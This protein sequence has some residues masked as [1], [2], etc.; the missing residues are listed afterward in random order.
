MRENASTSDYYDYLDRN[1]TFRDLAI[2]GSGTAV[3]VRPDADPL[4]LNAAIVS[5]NLA[6]VL[7]IDMQ[8]GRNFRLEEDVP[9]GPSVTVLT[10]RL[11]RDA[12]GADPRVVGSSLTIDDRPFEV[13][14]VLPAGLDYPARQTD[15]WVPI[16]QSRATAVRPQHWV[17][18][19]GRLQA[20]ATVASAQADMAR[21]MAD[22]EVE[23]A[24]DNQN[25]GAFVEK[26]ADVGRAD[27]RSTLWVLFASVLAVLAIACV[28]VANLLLARG[29]SRSRELAVLK[30]VGAGN[31]HITRKFIVEG[32][33][34]TALAAASG[35]GLAAGGVRLLTVL[36]PPS[37]L[38]LGEPAMNLQVLTFALGTGALICIGFGL[39]PALQARGLDVHEHLKDGGTTER[40]TAG[41]VLR[42]MLVAG[43]LSLAVVLLLGATLLIGT[44]RNLQSIDPGF[45]A[46]NSL[47]V[48][49]ALPTRYEGSLDTYPNWPVMQQFLS[50]L[51]A[52]AE[53]IPGIESATVVT[54]HPLDAGFTNSFRIEG[55]AYDPSQGEMTT[56]L[57]TPGYFE[58]TGV[59]LLAGRRLD[60]SDRAGAPDA[61][62]LNQSAADRYFPEGDAVGK[63]IAFWGPTF[64]E[65]VGIIGNERL[66]GLTAEIPPAMYVSMYQ[67]PPLRGGKDDVDGAHSGGTAVGGRRRA[68]RHAQGRPRHSG[69]QRVDHGSD[70]R[71]RAG[72]RAVRVHGAEPIRWCGALFGDAWRAR[73]A[74]LSG[75]A[76]QSRSGRAHGSGRDAPGRG[77][78]GGEAGRLDD[79][80]RNR[81]RARSGLRR[82][83]PDSGS[84][85]RGQRDR[86][87][88]VRGRRDHTRDRGAGRSGCAGAPC[89]IDQP[90]VV[91]T[92]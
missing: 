61:I 68:R 49:F 24:N 82:V 53:A 89:R 69:L 38:L 52:E 33:L 85:L 59:E 50:D 70:G 30:A 87:D 47:R 76:A 23:Y 46:E 66:H 91:A 64:R 58:T 86:A 90:G 29:A 42:R 71:R 74:G 92:R 84:A 34:I 39:L 73:R 17:R 80:D 41:F 60:D 36:A 22:L 72:S 12:F 79:R 43:Q 45:R 19:V 75:G 83:R 28:N 10:D 31:R 35:I 67:A 21:I 32:A 13:V 15:A 9:G 63:R 16:Q 56:R 11:W 62:V 26:L 6:A 14:G 51:T 8:L 5:Q 25:R 20:G 40:G 2:Y 1:H 81:A 48:D 77:E 65:V 18:V 78:H 44:V 55:H 88:G 27:V 54:N 57:V 4:Q 37:L 7:G 3:L